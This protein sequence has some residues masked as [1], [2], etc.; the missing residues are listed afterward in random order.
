MRKLADTYAGKSVFVTGHAGFK[1]RWL[2]R[3]LRELE[4]DISGFDIASVLGADDARCLRRLSAAVRDAQPDF[5]FHLAAQAF[6]PTGYEEPIRTFETNAMG[7]VNLLEALRSLH[8]PCAV[9][10]V[11]TDKVYGSDDAAPHVEEDLLFGRCPYSASK[12]AAESAVEAYRRGYFAPEH[13]IA[14]ATARAGNVIGPGDAGEGRLIPNAIRA[15]RERR[16]IPVYNPSAVRPWQYIDDVIRGYLML[17]A[18]LAGASVGVER[19]RYAQAWNFGPDRSRTTLE[20][21]EALIRE[22]GSGIW[23]HTPTMLRETNALHI[24]SAKARLQ[25]GWAPR[26]NFDDAI[27]ATVRWYR[28]S[29]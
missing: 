25:L 16:P 13:R 7:T 22:W 24:D 6:V 28:E 20:V 19:A 4:A 2:C 14:V 21:A 1:G 27:R 11:T 5:A 10:V 29:N 26:W 12:V 8:K 17:G 15:L 18:A 9:V 3:Q 23:A